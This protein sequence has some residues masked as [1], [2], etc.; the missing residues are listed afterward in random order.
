VLATP[1]KKILHF[2]HCG[3]IR[4]LTPLQ[5]LNLTELRFALGPVAIQLRRMK[6]LRTIEVT[7]RGTFAAAEFWRRYDS[8][9]FK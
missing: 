9:E 8:G 4:D 6:S 5:D 1:G 3:G 2:G 7:D